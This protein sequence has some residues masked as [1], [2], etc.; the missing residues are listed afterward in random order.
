MLSLITLL[1]STAPAVAPYLIGSI[2]GFVLASFGHLIKAPLLIVF[3]IVLIGVT[4]AL[5]VIVADPSVS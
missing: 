4:S 3:G 1:A 2:L 5:F